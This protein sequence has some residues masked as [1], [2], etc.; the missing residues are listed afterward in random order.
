MDEAEDG[1]YASAD[2]IQTAEIEKTV[3]KN[4]N[5]MSV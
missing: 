5:S 2:N 1:E 4:G 3:N